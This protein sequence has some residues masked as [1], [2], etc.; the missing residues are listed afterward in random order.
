M[1]SI[2]HNTKSTSA[3]D[4]QPPSMRGSPLRVFI[5]D[6]D[7]DNLDSK[8][9][10]LQQR[11]AE[12]RRREEEEKEWRLLE[13]E[14]RKEELWAAMTKAAVDKMVTEQAEAE[15]KRQAEEVAR[16]QGGGEEAGG[17]RGQKR[18]RSDS[19]ARC[20]KHGIECEWPE[21][22][23]GKSCLACVAKKAKCLMVA[24]SR[25]KKKQAQTPESDDEYGGV[26]ARLDRMETR[27]ERMETK[28]DKLVSSVKWRMDRVLVQVEDIREWVAGEFF[29]Q[30]VEAEEEEEESEVESRGEPEAAIGELEELW[31]EVIAYAREKAE[32]VERL[33]REELEKK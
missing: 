24:D 4:E 29:A 10:E 9:A 30:D 19:C 3:H 23:R 31:E 2:T 6:D 8:I 12:H 16:A 33:R 25:P 1:S 27:L 15:V 22:R 18:P 5:D 11:K 21:S 28:L 17:S 13:M 7:D 14:R 26:E 32:E 20:H